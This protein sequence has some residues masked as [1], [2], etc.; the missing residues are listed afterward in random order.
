VKPLA[1]GIVGGGNISETHARAA[2]EIAGLQVA[3]VT[4]SNLERVRALAARYG[5]AVFPEVDALVRH[6]PLDLVLL[7]SPSGLHGQQGIAAARQGL[8]VLTEKPVDV[9]VE[10]ADALIDECETAG[11]RLGVFFQDRFAPAFVRVK[12]ALEAGAL[13]RPLL[14]SARVKWWRQPEYYSASRWRGTGDLDGGGALINQGIHTV[15][16]LLW[17]LGDV[18]RVFATARTARHAIEVED[19]L[20]ATL[21]FAGGAVATLEATTAAFPGYARQVEISGTEGTI[22]L[23]QDRLLAADLRTP[24]PGLAPGETDS[25]PSARSP[26]VSDMRGH[27]AA[28]EDFV[29]AIREGHPPRCDGREG[30]RSLAVVEALYR[31]AREGAPV[32]IGA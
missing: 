8:H 6:R 23:H 31:S 24:W 15:D 30:R 29:A 5:A 1:V 19:T 13:G 20:V 26:T 7:G 17:L 14:A 9:S 11:V 18:Q 21:E 4:G 16:L 3:A 2:A 32:T 12:A 25:N 10:R 22:V 28:L 27:R